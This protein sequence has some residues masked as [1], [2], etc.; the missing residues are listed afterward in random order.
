VTWYDTIVIGGGQA[1]LAAG[2]HL[3][4]RDVDF[5]ILDAGNRAGSSW[6]N[7]WDSLRLFT[8]ARYS[9]LPGMAFPAAPG[10][11][12][13]KD[14]VADYLERYAERFD[15][16]VRSN[17]PVTSLRR[18]GNEF[19]LEAGGA[20]LTAGNVVV[21][22]GPFQQPRTP[23]LAAQL[24]ADIRQLHSRDYRN[25]SQLPPGAVLVVGAGNSGAQIA[26]ELSVFRDVTLAGRDIPRLPRK[27]LG[28][29]VFRWVWP[30]FRRFT[31]NTRL[32]R[33]LRE[34]SRS[35]DPLI[36]IGPRDFAAHGIRRVG[37][38][39]EVRDGLPWAEGAPL[40]VA[41][42]VWATGFAPD[43]RWIEIPAFNP[44]GAPR[45]ARGVTEVPGLYF[46]GL[47]FQ[48]RQSSALIGGVGEDADFIAGEIVRRG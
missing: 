43:Y 15:L 20:V 28:A 48:Y 4:R 39:T 29:D 41:S 9:G 16:P 8:P 31:L 2:Y 22:T 34:R 42:V 19:V 3:A 35:G 27:V 45:H 23:A 26:L 6:R 13:D 14:E 36:G 44:D 10:H 21:A 38:V 7:R 47:R 37:R 46:V 40:D 24:R 11:L 5:T 18:D 12:P 33:R 17:M 30:A 32:G 1:G 25:P